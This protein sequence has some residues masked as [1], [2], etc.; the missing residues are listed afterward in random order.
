ME[1]PYLIRRTRLY[2]AH[3]HTIL[4]LLNANLAYDRAFRA[5]AAGQAAAFT[6]DLE[7][8]ADGHAAALDRARRTTAELAAGANC[9]TD[10]YLLFRYSVLWLRPLEAFAALVRNMAN[11]HRRQPYWEPV[12]WPALS[13]ERLPFETG[14]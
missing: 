11:F 10:Q 1:Q 6:Q 8:F 13:L 7:Q 3:L 14:A 5:R 9:G 2:L 12:D 4:C